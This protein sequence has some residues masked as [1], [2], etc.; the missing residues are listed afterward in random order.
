MRTFTKILLFLLVLGL[1]KLNTYT[2]SPHLSTAESHV[3]K[4]ITYGV[5]GGLLVNTLCG[6]AAPGLDP[7]IPSSDSFM[8]CAPF[9]LAGS[10]IVARTYV[11][12]TGGWGIE[13][14]WYANQLPRR[15]ESGI[16]EVLGLEQK[17]LPAKPFRQVKPEEV[18]VK[19]EL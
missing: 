4:T 10:V 11:F 8:S 17:P 18:P 15:V 1:A 7:E 16:R 13:Q 14:W 6:M 3:L 9:G 12:V 19:E 5:G 2:K